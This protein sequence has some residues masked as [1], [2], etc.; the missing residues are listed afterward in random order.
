MNWEEFWEAYCR[1]SGVFSGMG[2]LFGFDG[3]EE[4]EP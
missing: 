2:Y 3:S 1:E 4:T